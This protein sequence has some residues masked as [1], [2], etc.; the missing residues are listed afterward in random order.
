MMPPCTETFHRNSSSSSA[1]SSL[2]P[3]LR[4]VF[5]LVSFA[6]APAA[7]DHLA[8]RDSEKV[9]W[10]SQVQQLQLALA[11]SKDEVASI[12]SSCE[13]RLSFMTDQCKA[14][15]AAAAASESSAKASAAQLQGVKQEVSASEARV[16][17]L[18]AKCIA[19]EAEL[20]VEKE[21]CAAAIAKAH[22]AE[23][24]TAAANQRADDAAVAAAAEVEAKQLEASSRLKLL[25][26]FF[27][28]LFQL[29][30]IKLF[31]LFF[32]LAS[33]HNSISCARCKRNYVAPGQQQIIISMFTKVNCSSSSSSSSSGSWSTTAASRT[34]SR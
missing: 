22:K 23:A 33:L 17:A 20:A 8:V 19:A 15:A 9:A 2:L 12:T 4:Q 11:A 1:I 21:V 25:Q 32:M 29:F 3:P 16:H 5:V 7:R 13:Q 27:I 18:A 34:F 26:L 10:A 28:K 31:Q 14:A 30:F 24:E 6:H